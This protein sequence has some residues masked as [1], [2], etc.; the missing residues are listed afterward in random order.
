MSGSFAA[1]KTITM[2]YIIEEFKHYK[3]SL[4]G[5]AAM[6]EKTDYGIQFRIPSGRV[7][8][9]FTRDF[10]K[11]NEVEQRGDLKMFFIYLRAEKYAAFIDIMR[12]EGPLYFY[13]NSE[14]NEAYVTTT[15]EPVGEGEVGFAPKLP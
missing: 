9:R 5:R 3:V 2:G 13:Y 14:T 11:E 4:F 12:N 1:S 6:G 7:V 10:S 15:D 8:L